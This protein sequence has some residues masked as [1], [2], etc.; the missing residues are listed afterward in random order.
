MT[1][2]YA[3]RS[4]RPVPRLQVFLVCEKVIVERDSLVAS[5]IGMLDNIVVPAVEP[6]PTFLGMPW[7]MMA[8]WRR[9]EGDSKTTPHEER[10][11]LLSPSGGL[12]VQVIGPLDF[13]E[14]IHRAVVGFPRFPVRE[15]GD[16]QAVLSYREKGKEEWTAVGRYTITV[17]HETV[18][19]PPPSQP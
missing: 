2:G 7:K 18:Q 14:A 3:S 11:Q 1:V 17:S 4:M 6:P 15:E 16:Y 9:E 13:S 8:Q 12:L 19:K 5:V 10:F